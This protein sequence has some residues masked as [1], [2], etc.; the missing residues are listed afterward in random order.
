MIYLLIPLLIIAIATGNKT[1]SKSEV[2]HS[3]MVVCETNSGGDED[4]YNKCL[5]RLGHGENHVVAEKQEES[6]D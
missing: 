2:K 3:D 1:P 5:A 4:K 6:H